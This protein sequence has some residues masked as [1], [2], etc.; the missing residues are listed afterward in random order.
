MSDDIKLKRFG[1]YLILD[2]LVDGGM[3]KICRAKFLSEETNKIVAIKVIQPQFSNDE[4]FRTMFMD[5]VKVS[6]GLQ[7]PNIVQTFDYGYYNKQ[8]YV[9]MEYCDGQNLKGYI[10]KL[11]KGGYVFPIEVS[12]YI[13]SQACQGLFYAHTLTDKMTGNDLNIIHRDISPHNIM[14]TYDGTVKI[15]DFGIA[16]ANSNAEVTQSGMIKGKLSY[17]APEYLEGKTLDPRYDQFSLGTV[18]WEMVCARKLFH[19]ANDLSI[20][21]KIQECDIPKPSSINP[22][23]TPE[24]DAIILRALSRDREKRYGNLNEMNKELTKFLYKYK[25]DFSNTDV[26]GF[27]KTLFKEQIQKDRETFFKYGK[28]DIAPYL[29]DLEKEGR[30]ASS[31][32]A[33]STSTTSINPE[34]KTASSRFYNVLQG[35]LDQDDQ[36]IIAKEATRLQAKQTTNARITVQGSDTSTRRRTVSK[37]LKGGTRTRAPRGRER[38][39]RGGIGKWLVAACVLAAAWLNRDAL[40]G[41][42]ADGGGAEARS[43]ASGPGG[44]LVL[45]EFDLYKQKVFVNGREQDI[46]YRN[47]VRVPL[48]KPFVLRVQTPKREHYVTTMTLGPDEKQKTVAVPRT[49]PARYSLIFTSDPSC[50]SGA[51]EFSL[52]GEKRREPLPL[53]KS[54]PLPFRGKGAE[55]GVTV[56]RGDGIRRA[57]DVRFQYAAQTLDLCGL[58][59]AGPPRASSTSR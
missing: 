3:G 12:V 35:D 58:A 8:L 14:V 59:G 51:L 33:T 16:K 44:V 56:V 40:M 57:L 18:L 39:G 28:I 2:H 38:G 25:P 53:A 24:L 6:F 30:K 17:L 41:R 20:L 26:A 52:F 31:S 42:G 48:G 15:I 19:E 1:K 5:E 29:K 50:L 7:H 21:K 49:K 36:D 47:Q 54:I 10:D 13:A 46:D 32:D 11:S 34:D 4:A 9:A 23:V 37:A 55:Y 27:A 22:K 45:Q 43:T